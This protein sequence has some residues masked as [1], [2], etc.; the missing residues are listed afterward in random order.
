MGQQAA[1]D[2]VQFQ[3]AAV[4]APVANFPQQQIVTVGTFGLVVGGGVILR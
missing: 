3:R 2:G 4:T 1:A